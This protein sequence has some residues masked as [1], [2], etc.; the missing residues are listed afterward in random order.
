LWKISTRCN[1]VEKLNLVDFVQLA[2]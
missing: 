2:A 1:Q